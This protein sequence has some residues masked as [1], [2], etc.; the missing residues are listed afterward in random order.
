[1]SAYKIY[2]PD[3]T[4]LVPIKK[5]E[6]TD[7]YMGDNY[8]SANISSPS[9]IAWRVGCYL[10]FRGERYTLHALPTE[11][12]VARANSYGGAFQ[13][14]NVVF[15]SVDEELRNAMFLDYVLQDNMI[16]YTSLPNFSF[17]CQRAQDFADRLQANLNRVYGENVW[18]VLVADGTA[19]VGQS[20]VFSNVSCWD[21]LAQA[22][23][24]LDLNFIRHGRTITIGTLDSEIQQVMVY[25]KGNGLVSI[26]RSSDENQ[27][28]VTRLRAYGNTRNIPHDYYRKISA[29]GSMYVPN[30]MLPMFR[31]DRYDAYVDSDN[32]SSLGIREHTLFFDGSNSDLPDIYPSIEGMT[33]QTL[34]D[35]MTPEERTAQN[36]SMSYDQ[37][38]LNE[39]LDADAVEGDGNIPETQTSAPMF[40]ILIKNIGFNIN[41][42]LTSGDTPR[43]SMKS[44]TCAGREFEISSVTR[45]VLDSGAWAYSLRC[46]VAQDESINQYF[47]NERFQLHVGDTFVLLGI[48]MPEVYITTAEQRL[49]TA[50]ENWLSENDDTKFTFA[51]KVN[52]IYLAENPS[53]AQSLRAGCV[54]HIV[55]NDLGIDEKETI[56]QLKISVGGAQIPEYELTLSDEVDPTLAERVANTVQQSITNIIYGGS[57]SG[58]LI[59]TSSLLNKYFKVMVDSGGRTYLLCTVDLASQ[60]GVTAYATTL[61]DVNKIMDGVI[62]DDVTITKVNGKLTVIRNG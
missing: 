51:P 28:I 52:N 19:I 25:G 38:N 55:D 53:V 32:I 8:V 40:N 17:Y 6:L 21:A 22:C 43:I 39:I 31:T 62:C 54:L 12:K 3:S 50:A 18:S 30:L 11:K 7:T 2:N 4:E 46:S 20:L 13:Y 34:Y 45:R 26:E 37:G 24:T 15:R 58:E 35:G 5:F 61:A 23:N 33:T 56:S 60:Y 44:G 48:S 57:T 59:T 49:Q 29:T 47:P 14:E 42:M 27:K 16:H 1:M 36:I 9:P 10:D 41:D